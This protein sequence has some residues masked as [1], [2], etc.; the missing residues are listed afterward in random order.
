VGQNLDKPRNNVYRVP[1]AMAE[2]KGR[3]FCKF[4]QVSVT[5]VRPKEAVMY[6]AGGSCSGIYALGCT[7]FPD[8]SSAMQCPKLLLLLSEWHIG[9]HRAWG[10]CIPDRRTPGPVGPAAILTCWRAFLGTRELRA[11]VLIEAPL[12]FAVL[13]VRVPGRKVQVRGQV[14]ESTHEGRCRGY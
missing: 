11:C 6:A 4:Y 3:P 2:A 10:V 1:A 7:C 9:S 13:H 14:L 5:A 8:D 12:C